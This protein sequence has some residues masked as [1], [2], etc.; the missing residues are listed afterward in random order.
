MLLLS[1]RRCCAQT[2]NFLELRLGEVRR[3]L[4]PRTP[5]NKG[6]RK[7]R[8]PRLLYAPARVTQPARE[9]LTQ[10]KSHSLL[11]LKPK[12]YS[13]ANATPER[14]LTLG[15]S[16]LIVVI[17]TAVAAIATAVHTSATAVLTSA[18][19]VELAP[20]GPLGIL[21]VGD[22]NVEPPRVFKELQA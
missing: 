17:A 9:G 12:N 7:C 19:L 6:I 2:A 13:L 1:P 11:V 5:V 21:L 3:I 22:V 8:G 16:T 4:L 18:I 20:Y 15:P 10:R 14:S